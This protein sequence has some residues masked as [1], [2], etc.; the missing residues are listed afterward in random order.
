[1]GQLTRIAQDPWSESVS[2]PTFEPPPVEVKSCHVPLTAERAEELVRTHLERAGSSIR[3]GRDQSPNTT[4]AGAS[5]SGA[6]AAPSQGNGIEATASTSTSGLS[7]S[8]SLTANSSLSRRAAAPQLQTGLDYAASQIPPPLI[9]PAEAAPVAAPEGDLPDPTEGADEAGADAGAGRGDEGGFDGEEAARRQALVDAALMDAWIANGVLAQD[10]LTCG[11][12]Q[13][14][15][16]TPSGMLP[17]RPGS[18]QGTLSR[19]LSCPE[20]ILRI[21]IQGPA[22]GGTGGG[23]EEQ[24]PAVAPEPEDALEPLANHHMWMFNRGR[25]DGGGQ[26]LLYSPSGVLNVYGATWQPRDAASIFGPAGGAGGPWDPL[27]ASGAGGGA[28]PRSTRVGK[29]IEGGAGAEV[30]RTL[31]AVI[32]QS[33]CRGWQARRRIARMRSLIRS[34]ES[35]RLKE[36]AAAEALARER[37]T[38]RRRLRAAAKDCLLALQ[39][40]QDYERTRARLAAARGLSGGAAAAPPP[41]PPSIPQ[42]LWERCKALGQDPIEVLLESGLQSHQIEDIISQSKL[43][44]QLPRRAAAAAARMGVP[45]QSVPEGS[46]R[47][48]SRSSY[49]GAPRGSKG[50]IATDEGGAA[51][52][53]AAAAAAAAAGAEAGGAAAATTAGRGVPPLARRLSLPGRPLL[54]SQRSLA[55]AA[56]APRQAAAAAP[57]PV[58]F[59]TSQLVEQMLAQ[60]QLQSQQ[61][62]LPYSSHGGYGLQVAG[63]AAASSAAVGPVIRRSSGPGALGAPP[64]PPPLQRRQPA[65]A[66]ASMTLA[67]DNSNNSLGLRQG[68]H[69][70]VMSGAH[71]GGGF[72]AGGSPMR[73][74]PPPPPPP[75]PQQQWGGLGVPRISAPVPLV[76]GSSRRMSDFIGSSASVGGA[77]QGLTAAGGSAAAAPAPA[78]PLRAR[79]FVVSDSGAVMGSLSS[80]SGGGQR[81]GLPPPPPLQPQTSSRVLLP[82]VPQTPPLSAGGGGAAASGPALGTQNSGDLN[83]G[84]PAQLAPATAAA[85]A[86]AAVPGALSPRTTPATAPPQPPPPPQPQPPLQPPPHHLPQHLHGLV[87]GSVNSPIV[88]SPGYQSS[89]GCSTDGSPALLRRH[90]F[91]EQPAGGGGGGSGAT[92]DSA[93]ALARGAATA[94]SGRTSTPGGGSGGGGLPAYLPPLL[95]SQGSSSYLGV[96]SGGG[97]SGT[98]SPSA[99]A[100]AAA[101]AGVLLGSPSASSAALAATGSGAVGD[102]ALGRV[103]RRGSNLAPQPGAQTAST[104]SPP[105]MPPPVLASPKSFRRLQSL[106]HAGA[107]ATAAAAVFAGAATAGS[108]PAPLTRVLSAGGGS[109]AAAVAAADAAGS[110]TSR[111]SLPPPGARPPVAMSSPGRIMARAS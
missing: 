75:P 8:S 9:S 46:S 58:V 30:I 31:A 76:R 43:T 6:A 52:V 29:L 1:M 104:A 95:P 18:S 37:E 59:N 73:A 3:K 100:S 96:S 90:S 10:E 26:G 11:L 97:S 55:A 93:T 61:Q 89:P 53:A 69:P 78:A 19:R 83:A 60:Q 63:N 102:V 32:I 22:A 80:V 66:I 44:S 13:A 27:A 51:A 79:S 106:T 91:V 94:A 109:G 103:A 81:M 17:L 68:L 38:V 108:P 101:A 72:A 98:A 85:A 41:P 71:L 70:G 42:A 36:R 4:D 40:Q 107:S 57:P 74:P 49:G 33:Y 65:P 21:N 48:A 84:G 88:R 92:V 82:A 67:I 54:P 50:G 15:G 39:A 35:R 62:Y 56:A 77:G 25:L 24:G 64:P 110:L 7:H 28:K 23:G 105:P 12:A 99:A 2:V 111:A 14:P 16:A 47:P 45:L 34:E 5:T 86:A 20:N 87:A